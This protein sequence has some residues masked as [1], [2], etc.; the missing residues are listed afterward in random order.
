MSSNIVN[1][2]TATTLEPAT[3]RFARNLEKFYESLPADEQHLLTLV[4]ALAERAGAGDDTDGYALDLHR[5]LLA[6]ARPFVAAAAVAGALGSIGAA[7]LPGMHTP[8]AHADTGTVLPATACTVEKSPTTPAAQTIITFTNQRSTAV[9]V[10]WLD[11]SGQRQ[12]YRTL[13]A[14]ESYV[15]QT[16]GGHIWEVT[17]DGGACLGHFTALSTRQSG[18]VT[19]VAP[20]STTPPPVTTTA[21]NTTNPAPVVAARTAAPAPVV[22]VT[23]HGTF[24]DLSVLSE[25]RARLSLS[26]IDPQRPF[27]DAIVFQKSSQGL[28]S[29]LDVTVPDLYPGKSY[30]WTLTATGFDGQTATRQGNFRT[31]ERQ[32]VVDL[33]SITINDAGG[34]NLGPQSDYGVMEFSIVVGDQSFKTPRERFYDG[35]VLT[36]DKRFTFG[37]TGPLLLVQ[38]VGEEGWANIFDGPDT[39]FALGTLTFRSGQGEAFRDSFQFS[40]TNGNLRFTVNGRIQVSYR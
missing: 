26:V 24:A 21:T 15:Q 22:S 16:V 5:R 9:K 17:G 39:A 34:V 36:L 29:A 6:H 30:Q 10:Y 28:A 11:F 23:P 33:D 37:D 12:L 2:T 3:Q 35:S 8:S 18:Q 13:G 14:G 4:F 32:V 27:N 7:G 38:V 20:A 19:L 40:G 31:L 25:V 1:E